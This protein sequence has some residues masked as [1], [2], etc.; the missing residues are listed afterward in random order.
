MSS[1]LTFITNEENNKL[2]DRFA[3]LI[4]DSQFFDCLV[5]YFYTGLRNNLEFNVE[6][7]NSSDHKF[8]LD[9]FNKLISVAE[10]K[11]FIDIVDQLLSITSV[12]DYLDSPEKQTRV[13]MLE[14]EI[15]QLVYK[16]YDLT[17]GE[18]AIVENFNKGK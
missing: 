17:P 7:K 4:K 18:I 9:Q 6:L 15:D 2:V 12:P 3:A 8:A 10:E 5:G 13:K 1:D 16:L 11:P 14:K